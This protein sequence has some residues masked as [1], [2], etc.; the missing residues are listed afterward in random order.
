MIFLLKRAAILNQ[1]ETLIESKLCHVCKSNKIEDEPHFILQCPFYGNLRNTLFSNLNNIL[2]F[3]N[4][5][6]M[7]QDQQFNFIIV[8][9][10]QPQL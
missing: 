4:F 3:C 6:A 9:V 8:A 5:T 2:V 1:K 10:Y 7:D